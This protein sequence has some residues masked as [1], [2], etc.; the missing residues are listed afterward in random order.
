MWLC[1]CTMVCVSVLWYVW[2]RWCMM[3]GMGVLNYGVFWYIL[4]YV[5]MCM[6]VCVYDRVFGCILMYMGVLVLNS[7]CWCL[8]V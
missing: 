2:V 3:V 4:V 1:G 6:V 7:V 8:G 5:G